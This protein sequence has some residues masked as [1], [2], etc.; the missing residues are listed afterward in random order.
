MDLTNFLGN[1]EFAKYSSFQ[2]QGEAQKYKLI[3]GN[4]IGGDAGKLRDWVAGCEVG[5]SE[6]LWE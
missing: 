6:L 3:L 5:T 4:F 1:R 2:I